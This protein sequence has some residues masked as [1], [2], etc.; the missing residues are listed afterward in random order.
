MAVAPLTITSSRKAVADFTHPY[1]SFGIG[2]LLRIPQVQRPGLFSFMKPLSSHIWMSILVAGIVTIIL[3]YITAR[4]TPY[5]WRAPRSLCA[6]RHPREAYYAG[7]ENVLVN[8][9]TLANSAWYVMTTFLK[10]CAHFSPKSISTRLLG[11]FWWVFCLVIISAYTAN[12]AAVLTVDRRFLP[13]K[14]LDD[15]AYQK[16]I[17]FGAISDGSTA[18]FFNVRS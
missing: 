18:Q 1:L 7:Q 12:L 14:S 16:E 11:G 4:I 15:L 3:L 10:G 9:Y 8:N 2:V 13:I 6:I 17:S 5:E